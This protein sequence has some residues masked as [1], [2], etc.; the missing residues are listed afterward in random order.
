MRR[1]IVP[2]AGYAPAMSMSYHPPPEPPPPASGSVG[3]RVLAIAVCGA[4]LLGAVLL[5]SPAPSVTPPPA[6]GEVR[7]PQQ[8]RGVVAYKSRFGFQLCSRASLHNCV[9]EFVTDASGNRRTIR[10]GPVDVDP[11]P[12]CD[13]I[14]DAAS[15]ACEDAGA[16]LLAAGGPSPTWLRCMALHGLVCRAG[17]VVLDPR[18]APQDTNPGNLF[19][20]CNE[21]YLNG[22]FDDTL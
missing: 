8:L 20:R 19:V 1:L 2:S 11:V 5:V 4:G 17:S 18:D 7:A 9:L 3:L 16:D 15:A 21:G 10:M 22:N 12:S 6:A 13:G 14:T